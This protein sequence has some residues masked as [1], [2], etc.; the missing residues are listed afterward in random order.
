MSILSTE[1][2]K[3]AQ[4]INNYYYF[5]YIFLCFKIKKKRL[6]KSDEKCNFYGKLSLSNGPHCIF[7]LLFKTIR[8][9][10]KIIGIFENNKIPVQSC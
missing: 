6:S 3:I 5:V 8:V 10:F 7:F 2:S 4:I 1:L 9:G